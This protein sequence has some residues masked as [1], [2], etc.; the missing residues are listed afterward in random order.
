M[1]AIFLKKMIWRKD[2]DRKI[3]TRQKRAKYERQNDYPSRN[4]VQDLMETVTWCFFAYWFLQNNFNTDIS[5]DFRH[6]SAQVFYIIHAERL[7]D[8]NAHRQS[9]QQKGWGKKSQTLL[10]SNTELFVSVWATLIHCCLCPISWFI[11]L[12]KRR[13]V[14]T[15]LS[16]T[17]EQSI[18]PKITNGH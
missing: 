12:A 11:V 2:R 18:L 4:W 1:G 7:K 17:K 13:L 6:K 10:L 14:S 8:N 15:S 16:Y 5:Q 9:R 3:Y